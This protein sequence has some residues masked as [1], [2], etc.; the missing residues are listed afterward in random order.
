MS[1]SYDPT[2]LFCRIV[3]GEIPSTQIYRDEK[4][5]AFRDVNPQAPLHALVVPRA[6]IA[7]INV[8]EARDGAL[9]VAIVSAANAVAREQGVAESGYRLV[10]NVGR[11][12]GQTVFHMHLHLLGGRRL[13]WPPG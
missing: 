5:I 3:A 7:G 9:L 12:A 11:D 6:H 8:P 13:G 10:W 2:C 1:V 4:V